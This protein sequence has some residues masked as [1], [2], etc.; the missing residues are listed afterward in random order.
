MNSFTFPPTVNPLG[1][2]DC[3][4][5]Y[6][7]GFSMTVTAWSLVVTVE[8]EDMSLNVNYIYFA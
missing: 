4:E 5:I 7:K 2:R 8:P 3:T 6:N 1:L